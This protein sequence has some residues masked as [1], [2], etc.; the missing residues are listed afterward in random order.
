M[1]GGA[2]MQLVAYGAQDIYLTGNPTITHFKTVYR[3]CTNFSMESI[4]QY[5]TNGTVDFGNRVTSIISRNGDLIHQMYLEVVLPN[6]PP[7]SNTNWVRWT[8]NV[9]HYLINSI[10]VEIGGQ[11]ID[12]HYGD[13]LEI[14]SQLSVPAGQKNGYL[15]MIGQ[16]RT[17]PDGR[18]RGL[19]NSADINRTIFV[20]LQFWFCRNVG[21]S[22]PLISLQYHEVTISLEFNTL[23]NLLI[24]TDGKGKIQ[25]NTIPDV[26]TGLS[27]RLWVNYIFL[28]TEERWRFAE[29]AHEY[30]I[31]QLQFFGD[32]TIVAGT[33]TKNI[34]LEFNH[35]VKEMVWV[36]RNSIME[37]HKQ[38]CNYT[39][40]LAETRQ[41]LPVYMKNPYDCFNPIYSAKLTL[42]GYDRFAMRVGDYF[43]WVQPF[44]A[45]TNVP[46][47]RGINVYSFALQPEAHQPSGTCNFSRIDS[48]VLNIKM[49]YPGEL[50][51]PGKKEPLLPGLP[52]LDGFDGFNLKE[53][54]SAVMGLKTLYV[55][56][57]IQSLI[58]YIN[59]RP[60]VNLPGGLVLPKILERGDI[61]NLTTWANKAQGCIH[62]WNA[63]HPKNQDSQTILSIYAVQT[64]ITVIAVTDLLLQTVKLF[65]T[66][67]R[68]EAPPGLTKSYLEQVNLISSLTLPNYLTGSVQLLINAYPNIFYGQNDESTINMIMS[69]LNTTI[70]VLTK[71]LLPDIDSINYNLPQALQSEKISALFPISLTDYCGIIRSYSDYVLQFPYQIQNQN[72]KQLSYFARSICPVNYGGPNKKKKPE[73]GPVKVEPPPVEPPVKP[74]EP[75]KEDES[76]VL[77]PKNPL[78]TADSVI[79]V[80]AINYNILRIMSGMGGV[81]YSN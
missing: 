57:K 53:N 54:E 12:R 4:E 60:S 40:L 79:K 48:A 43:N 50:S 25:P 63:R 55:P 35:P 20:P 10:S 67:T 68:E 19:Q 66:V 39:T 77:P 75:V 17:F 37:Q 81:V 3:R 5:F 36:V 69:S 80:Y 32:T 22:L 18:P 58:N 64:Y 71:I 14:W 46:E 70:G 26:M 78:L 47:S 41:N 62:N 49:Y 23:D 45:H 13:W 34:I 51:T 21:L 61:K 76:A 59:S 6:I 65:I 28:D 74:A 38:W 1:T 8:D 7:G 31:E 11:M 16:D 72:P 56:E 15:N 33:Q 2:L 24:T 52:E 29:V 9:G 30:L 73:Q 42:N 27:A 44:E